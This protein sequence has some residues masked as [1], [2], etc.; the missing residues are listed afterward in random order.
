VNISNKQLLC[1]SNISYPVKFAFQN[2]LFGMM[3]LSFRV[4]DVKISAFAEVREHRVLTPAAGIK[5]AIFLI[6]S[7]EI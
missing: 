2:L 4:L 3:N 7:S 6:T 5:C 1:W